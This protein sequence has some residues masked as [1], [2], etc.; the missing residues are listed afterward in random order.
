MDDGTDKGPAHLEIQ[1]WWTVRHVPRPTAVSNNKQQCEL[2]VIF[3]SKTAVWLLHMLACIF[4]LLNVLNCRQVAKLDQEWLKRNMVQN[5]LVDEMV[6]L[7]VTWSYIFLI[8]GDDIVVP[9][10]TCI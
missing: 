3:N 2:P 6:H 10:K 9:I 4:L 1:F 5:A 8:K 7:A